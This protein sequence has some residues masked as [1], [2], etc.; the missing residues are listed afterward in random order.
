MVGWGERLCLEEL[1]GQMGG[2][3]CLEE[4]NGLGLSGKSVC[5]DWFVGELGEEAGEEVCVYR[6]NIERTS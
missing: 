5:M 1:N 3:V 4:F 6:K 2:Q